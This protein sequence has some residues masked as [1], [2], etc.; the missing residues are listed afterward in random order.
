MGLLVHDAAHHVM[1]RVKSGG[2]VPAAPLVGRPCGRHPAKVVWAGCE[3]VI[4][5]DPHQGA[6]LFGELKVLEV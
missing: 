1:V 6:V 5:T 2:L 4:G 3:E